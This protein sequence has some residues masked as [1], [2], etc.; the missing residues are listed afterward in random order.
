[1]QYSEQSLYLSKVDLI[2]HNLVWMR[3]A[4]EACQKGQEGDDNKHEL[5]VPVF[6][7]SSLGLLLNLVQHVCTLVRYASIICYRCG[8]SLS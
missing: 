4:I 1:M 2:K 6:T 8:S 3:D 7:D 5:I